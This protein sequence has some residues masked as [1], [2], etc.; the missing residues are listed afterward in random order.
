MVYC[1]VQ[2]WPWSS[3]MWGLLRNAEEL[4]N[5]ERL[6]RQLICLWSF[7]TRQDAQVLRTLPEELRTWKELEQHEELAMR[8]LQNWAVR[9]LLRCLA[10]RALKQKHW[11]C[12]RPSWPWPS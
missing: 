2:Q 12:V 5:L 4:K 3:T 10:V 9:A 8:A 7:D 1:L 6:L 11:A